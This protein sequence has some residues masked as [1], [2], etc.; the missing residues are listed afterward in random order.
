MN[1]GPNLNTL[2]DYISY[3][4]DEDRIKNIQFENQNR[5]YDGVI[6]RIEYTSFRGRLAKL[7]PKK[8]GYF[9]TFWEKD[10]EGNNQ[11][12]HFSN[13]PDKI[14]I[15]V[16]DNQFS[17]QFVFT[18][19]ILLEK[20]ILK[21]QS[22]KG[23]MAIRVYPTWETDLNSSAFKTQQWQTKYFIDTSYEFDK[24]KLMEIYFS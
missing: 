22:S 19:E 10:P 20:N 9:V 21:S 14:I 2:L 11:A 23:K 3:F 12:F 6:F 13:S 15:T 17:G 8:K 18:K 16:I 24:D 5:D 1:R 7:T 4:I